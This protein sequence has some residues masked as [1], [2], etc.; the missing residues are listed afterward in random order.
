MARHPHSPATQSSHL[1]FGDMSVLPQSRVAL[2]GLGRVQTVQKLQ[3]NE[4]AGFSR[5]HIIHDRKIKL[6]VHCIAAS[7]DLQPFWESSC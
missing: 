3:E 4:N 1:V 6:V 7:L 2:K 5:S